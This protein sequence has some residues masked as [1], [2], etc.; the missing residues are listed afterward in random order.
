MKTKI[1]IF[2]T[3]CAFAIVGVLNA[4]ATVNFEEKNS[5][6]ILEN[7][8][9]SAL[10]EKIATLESEINGN[11]D[12]QK[13]AQIVTRWI[14]DMA[15]AKATQKVMERGFVAPNEAFSSFENEAVNENN[16]ETTDFRKEAQL[17]TKLIAD[18]EEAKAIQKVMERG[19]V[20]P[21]EAFNSF[22]NEAVNEN[23]VETTD[24]RKEAQLITKLIADQE[25]AKAIQKV[26]ER[27]F[28]APNEAFNSF[29]NEAANEN[30]VETTDFRKEAQLMT[31][32][33][34][35]K[36]EAKAI[37]KLIAEGKLAENK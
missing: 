11:V 23:S 34:A 22:E 21:S 25:E 13:E 18:Q 24:F 31:K 7:E 37:Q 32:L 1:R 3:V 14:V 10:N 35:D 27:G 33:I 2:I 30:N 20:S 9:L 5:G 29:E 12:Y 16:V 28:V 17:I 15:E 36:E 26:M 8:S 4:S 6:L 19:F